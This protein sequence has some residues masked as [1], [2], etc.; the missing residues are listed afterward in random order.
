MAYTE[1]FTEQYQLGAIE[2]PDSL[3]PAA[4]N[5]A[6]LAMRDFHRAFVLLLVGDISGAGTVDFLL[7]QATTAA[8]GGPA[9]AIAGKAI[10]QLVAADDDVYCGIELRT[11]ELDVAGGFSFIR[12]VLTTG[13]AAAEVA[14]VVFKGEPARFQ[15]T[16]VTGFQEIIT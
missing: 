5:G 8:G 2:F 15:P 1:R 3:G 9:K 13:V 16:I 11:E 14:V 6:W 10:T 7:Q 12:W 4:T